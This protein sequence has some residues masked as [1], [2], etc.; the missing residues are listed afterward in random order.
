MALN[1]I[2]RL[3]Q[4]IS[5]VHTW[6]L[7]SRN[8]YSAVYFS[9][10]LLT[11]YIRNWNLYYYY[12]TTPD[13][14]SLQSFSFWEMAFQEL[15]PFANNIFLNS[16]RTLCS[17]WVWWFIV[18]VC[19]DVVFWPYQPAD[20]FFFFLLLLLLLAT[21]LCQ[22]PFQPPESRSI[23]PFTYIFVWMWWSCV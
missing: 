18:C 13:V 12:H 17:G 10:R 2:Y 20:N 4:F 7:S 1:L 19:S 9:K 22:F 15:Y 3:T 11:S 16:S 8:I 5:L 21:C 6:P 23:T 14:L